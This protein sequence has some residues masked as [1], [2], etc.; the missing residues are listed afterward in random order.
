MLM[1]ILILLQLII[2]ISFVLYSVYI[3]SEYFL[4]KLLN[5][6]VDLQL[7]D[8]DWYIFAVCITVFIYTMIYHFVSFII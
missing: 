6:S 2:F 5:I 4:N 3:I 8:I 7:K 1:N